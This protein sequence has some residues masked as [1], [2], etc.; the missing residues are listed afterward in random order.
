MKNNL[1]K[2]LT[3]SALLLT[4][5]LGLLACGANTSVNASANIGE[6][7]DIQDEATATSASVP[8]RQLS[9]VTQD[10][11]G[12]VV[13]SEDLF[14]P[15]E[16]TMVNV[17]A[18]WCGFCVGELSELEQINDRLAAKNCQIVGVCADVE[19]E[20]SLNEATA[21]LQE[22]GVTY[23][24]LITWDE[25]YETLDMSEGCPTSFFVNSNG[26]LVGNP[27]SGA[28]VDEYEDYIDALLEGTVPPTPTS[29]NKL[30]SSTDKA[31][32]II[33]V[34][35]DSNPVPG[36]MVQFCTDDTCMMGVTDDKGIASFEEPAGIYDVHI[37]KV[38][39]GYK[40]HTDAYKTEKNNT[41][42]T[43]TIEKN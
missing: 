26:E 42:L 36:A 17:W 23:T 38:P 39:E 27:I 16:I 7:K 40:K 43:I 6:K 30:S 8:G 18:T 10:L 24:N 25:W 9:F 4:L 12:N 1:F 33:V 41:V 21:L 2:K 32:Q 14:A 37:L 3:T 34:D 11:D 31:Y 29:G 20:D 35:T 19:D 28:L 5:T 15:C 22:N 13:S